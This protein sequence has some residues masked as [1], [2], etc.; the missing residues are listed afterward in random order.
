MAI[1]INRTP[2]VSGKAA[3]AL[4]SKIE[5]NDKIKESIDFTK[6]IEK[7]KQILAKQS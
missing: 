4:Q 3:D 5:Q 7:A 2:I 1:N 6:E